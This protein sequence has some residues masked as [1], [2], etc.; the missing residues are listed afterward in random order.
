MENF[1]KA[2]SLVRKLEGHELLI[3]LNTTISE[4][5]TNQSFDIKDSIL[6]I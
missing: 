6:R 5:S 2:Y 1:E 4:L 3:L